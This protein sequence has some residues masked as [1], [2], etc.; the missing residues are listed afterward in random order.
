MIPAVRVPVG[1]KIRIP[2]EI[3]LKPGWEFD[4]ERRVFVSDRGEEFEPRGELPKKTKIVHK[5]PALVEAARQT[6]ANL[7]EDEKNL[8]RHLQIILPA[9]EPPVKYLKTIRDWPWVAEAS[10]PPEPS[11]PGVSA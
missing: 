11:L 3:K 2:I 10:L 1:A 7:S 5:T 4:A 8:L 6:K 9:N